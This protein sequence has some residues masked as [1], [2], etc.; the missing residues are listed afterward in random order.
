MKEKGEKH[1]LMPVYDYA[2]A[3]IL[4]ECGI[5]AFLVGDSV[6]TVVMGREDD[7]SVTVDEMIYHTQ[8]VVRAAERALVIAD[9]PFMSYQ[10][11][12]DEA[13]RNAGRLI[14]EGGADAV[15][16]EGG[17]V[18]AETIGA[19]VGAGIP[20]MAHI[21][22]LDQSLKLTGVYKIRGRTQEDKEKLLTDAK[23]VEEAGAFLV[24]LDGMTAD[25][26]G[27]ISRALRIPTCGIGA[28]PHCDGC[29]LNIYDVIGLTV[30][31]EAK[32]VKRY[33]NVREI[34]F[35]AVKQF[36]KEVKEGS[37]PDEEHTYH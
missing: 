36:K 3:K 19:L 31:F 13:R 17:V 5:D 21:G 2:L 10:V 33:V 35:D 18:V 32:F 20:V 25:I 12:I 7:F 26:A 29:S 15:K 9:M 11:N 23:A 1:T 30:G 8:A 24:G 37:F 22:I 34:I 14:K 16:L 6:G 27:E 4:D 28:G